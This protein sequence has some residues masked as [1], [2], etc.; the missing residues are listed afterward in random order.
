[1][2]EVSVR[3]IVDDVAQAVA[4]YTEYLGFDVD[5]HPATGFARLSRGDFKLYL[6]QPGV[7]GGG[8]A[9]PDGQHPAPGGWNRIRIVVEN[10]EASIQALRAAGTTFRN[11]LV[12]G[13]G[14]K[15]ILLED[16]A[17]NP[18]ELF[19]PHAE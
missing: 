7:G 5:M 9:M 3:Y 6:N 11:E 15:Q 4:F 13:R 12:S 1:M 2:T 16:P 14:G 19:E 18:V 8:Q 10:I 17:G